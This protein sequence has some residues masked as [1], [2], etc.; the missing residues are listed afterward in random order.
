MANSKTIPKTEDYTAAKGEIK[1]SSIAG[2][3]HLTTHRIY[4]NSTMVKN[5]EGAVNVD[6]SVKSGDKIFIIS[7]INKPSGTSPFASLTVKIANGDQVFPF[8]YS[9]NEPDFDEVIYD[10]TINI[11]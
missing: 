3:A 5:G 7:T 9:S 2:D 6:V 4:L 8:E 1:I 11:I 10:V